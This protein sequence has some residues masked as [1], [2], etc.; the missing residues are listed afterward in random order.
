MKPTEEEVYAA[1][2]SLAA[3]SKPKTMTIPLCD[4]CCNGIDFLL[5]EEKNVNVH[6][7][8]CTPHMLWLTE[9]EGKEKE[10]VRTSFQ[11]LYG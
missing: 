10:E 4:L 11:G 3:L 8:L 1:A 7:N 9:Q 5:D 6:L 2:Q